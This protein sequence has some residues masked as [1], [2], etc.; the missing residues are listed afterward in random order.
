MNSKDPVVFDPSAA[1]LEYERVE[2]RGVYDYS[3]EWFIGPRHE[4][5][6]DGEKGEPGQYPF[7]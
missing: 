5:T 2:T 1:Y 4:I 3:H 7:Q 6:P